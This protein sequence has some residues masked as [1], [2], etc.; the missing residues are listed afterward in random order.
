VTVDE[1]D[2]LKAER[3]LRAAMRRA[4]RRLTRA[5][6]RET[7]APLSFSG[8]SRV[9]GTAACARGS[10]ARASAL[11]ARCAAV[12]LPPGTPGN[13]DREDGPTPAPDHR[14]SVAEVAPASRAAGDGQTGHR[15]PCGRARLPTSPDRLGWSWREVERRRAAGRDGNGSHRCD[16]ARRWLPWSSE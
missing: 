6:P 15:A 16:W 12:K 1:C 11:R 7:T 8:A 14:G 13:P 3:R 10:L 4:A 5:A 9:L 2:G